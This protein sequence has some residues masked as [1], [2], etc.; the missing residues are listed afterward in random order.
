M[1][2]M[3][4]LFN[5]KHCYYHKVYVFNEGD[6]SSSSPSSSENSKQETYEQF[7]IRNYIV[8]ETVK[9][10][11]RKEQSQKEMRDSVTIIQVE[12]NKQLNTDIQDEK[13]KEQVILI[14]ILKLD[15]M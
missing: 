9:M 15:N 14:C 2:N 10:L 7:S 11:K 8:D 1:E 5:L 6:S 4:V 3:A 13:T 12:N